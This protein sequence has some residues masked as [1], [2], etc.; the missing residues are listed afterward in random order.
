[1]RG[2]WGSF[3]FLGKVRKLQKRKRKRE[4]KGE[5]DEFFAEITNKEQRNLPQCCFNKFS[6]LPSIPP[7][8]GDFIGFY[9]FPFTSTVIVLLTAIDFI[10]IVLQLSEREREFRVGD[11]AEGMKWTF[12]IYFL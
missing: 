2:G 3:L 9:F 10:F 1:L 12:K 7:N 4:H 6:F 5:S 11:F 8:D